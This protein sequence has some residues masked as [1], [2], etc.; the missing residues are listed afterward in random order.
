LTLERNLLRIFEGR[1]DLTT[2]R[3]ADRQS[4]SFVTAGPNYNQNFR[5][6]FRQCLS[7]R[8]AVRSAAAEDRT[9]LFHNISP[10]LFS[11][12]AWPSGRTFIVT[13]W[14]RKL[15]EIPQ[16]RSSPA[17]LTRI[18]AKVLNAARGT[19]C[20]TAAVKSSVI[21]DYGI[22]P[23]KAL[24]AHM[25]FDIARFAPSGFSVPAKPRVL[26]IGGDLKRKGGDLL[27][28]SFPTK[29]QPHCDLTFVTNASTSNVDGVR[30]VRNLAYED[31]RHAELLRSHDL[32]LLPT[33]QEGYP[34]VIG[35]AAAAGLG[36]VTTKY[37][38]GA[39]D[40]IIDGRTGFICQSPGSAIDKASEL[41]KN[42]AKI[43]PLKKQSR[44]HM[45]EH[46]SKEALAREYFT[47]LRGGL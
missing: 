27:L 7:L 38:L 19:I 16:K 42:P 33:R 37:A 46:F 28:E 13:D 40:V 24:R 8:R 29:F 10:A 35:E 36:V 18:H 15:S 30:F 41:V 2:Y 45:E 43:R 9:I 34:Q 4:R 44:A 32:L 3:F 47:I 39:P 17:W 12:G 22:T 11:F 31:P 1:C 25:P 21:N 14:T 26:F 20:L 23:S 5:D 6:R